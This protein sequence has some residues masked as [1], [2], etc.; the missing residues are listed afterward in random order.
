[1]RFSPIRGRAAC[2]N[3]DGRF[4]RTV[5][6]TGEDYADELPE[7][8][9]ATQ[10]LPETIR[11]II[12]RNASPDI[13]FRQSINPYRGCEHGCIYCYARPAHAYVDLSPGLDFETRI[14]FKPDAASQLRRALARP[15]YR[16]QTIALGANTDAYQPAERELRIT[17]SILEVLAE[18]RHPVAIV[19][20]SA[21]IERDLDVLQDL[22]ANRLT[23]VMISVT[24]L[25]DELKRT[26][27]PRT[28]SPSRRLKIIERLSSAGVPVGSMIAPVIPGLTDHEIE[29]IVARVAAAGADQAAYILLRLPHEVADLFKNWLEEH[30][31]LRARKVM[32]MIRQLRS[33]QINDPCFGSRMSGRGN[34][35]ILLRDRFEKACRRHRLST[36]A[37]P[38]LNTGAFRAPLDRHPQ[39]DLLD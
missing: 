14:F 18:C 2:N 36:G 30:H 4:A 3:P 16:C 9:H 38:R 27:E 29:R 12:S 37:S 15:G 23:R 33:G 5:S 39:L 13:N 6:D 11:S 8:S 26:M 35:A 10:L 17:R 7:I 19:T 21:L 20:K 34:L 24:T 22:A 32:S 1:M 31:P 25:D 28:A